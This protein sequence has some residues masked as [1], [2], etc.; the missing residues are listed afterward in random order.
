MPHLRLTALL[1]LVASDLIA[2]EPA[3]VADARRLHE[4]QRLPEARAAWEAILQA[5]PDHAEALFGLAITHLEADDAKSAVPPLEKLVGLRPEEARYHRVLG[6][7]YGLC[8]QQASIFSKLGLA[9][10]CIAA[11]DRAVELAPDDVSYRGAR[12]DF[13]SMAPGLAGG[14]RDKAEAE[15]AEIERLDPAHGALIRA[16]AFVRENKH[17]E[18]LAVLEELHRRTPENKVAVYQIGRVAAI[19]GRKLEGGAAALADYL[20]YTPR[21]GEPPLWAAHWRLGQI[22]EKQGS[23]EEARAHYTQALA[24]NASCEDARQAIERLKR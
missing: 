18:A 10:K 2:A 3:R 7:A 1:L 24:L 22:L 9:R 21:P 17:D 20:A 4:E 14:G 15:L 11:Y 23:I 16:E 5:E 12:Y 13:Y 8:A 19:S 6:D